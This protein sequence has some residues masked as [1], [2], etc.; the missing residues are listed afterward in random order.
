PL[1]S[2]RLDTENNRIGSRVEID[3]IVLQTVEEQKA[4]ALIQPGNDPEEW[5]AS[6]RI[7]IAQK[8]PAQAAADLVRALDLFPSSD[9]WFAPRNKALA[10]F[11]ANDEVFAELLKLRP[12]DT[13]VR[14]CRGRAQVGENLWQRA[15]DEY[16]RVIKARP[17]GDEW[18]EYA[19]LLLLNDDEAAYR[20]FAEW[21]I[22]KA[23]ANPEPFTAYALARLNSLVPRSVA[24]PSRAIAWA[25]QATAHGRTAR[26]GRPPGPAPRPARQ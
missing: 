26:F 24:D 8:R 16:E 5:L 18:F 25:R 1:T 20:E 22:N 23:G 10:E 3:S 7:H 6:G 2:L 11:V 4:L 17:G 15:M 13:M 21:A 19:A 12:D 14:I 9:S